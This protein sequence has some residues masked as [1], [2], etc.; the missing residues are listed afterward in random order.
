MAIFETETP[1]PVKRGGTEWQA[2][3]VCDLGIFTTIASRDTPKGVK[4]AAWTT[5]Q[6][7]IFGRPD[8][9]CPTVISIVLRISWMLIIK[10]WQATA[11]CRY[12]D[13]RHDIK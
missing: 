5:V 4:D 12:P 7:A 11:Y 8:K 6:D 10:E 13:F 2:D 3:H 9:V 1:L